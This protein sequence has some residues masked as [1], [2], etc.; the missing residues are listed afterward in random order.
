MTGIIQM[1][2]FAWNFILKRPQESLLKIKL[3][4]GKNDPF[5]YWY[6]NY[7][8]QRFVSFL[9]AECGHEMGSR[10][11]HFPPYPTIRHKAGD[12]VSHFPPNTAISHHHLTVNG[13]SNTPT[14]FYTCCS[15]HNMPCLFH[16]FTLLLDSQFRVAFWIFV[17]QVSVLSCSVGNTFYNSSMIS[18]HLE[19]GLGIIRRGIQPGIRWCYWTGSES[20]IRVAFWIFVAK[21]KCLEWFC[22]H[23]D[24]FNQD[25]VDAMTFLMDYI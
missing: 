2:N 4:L 11:V 20:E 12:P 16:C 21:G 10:F 17:A 23:Y 3:F 18:P 19:H 8:K 7:L 13:M 22:R 14:F 15:S 1:N 9:Q 25:Y 6:K 24:E 5:L